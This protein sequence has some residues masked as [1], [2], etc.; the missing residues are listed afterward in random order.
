MSPRIPPLARLFLWPSLVCGLAR[1]GTSDH[2]WPTFRGPERT[3]VS[4]ESGLLQQW[5]EGGPE[6]VWETQGAGRGYASLAICDGRIYTLGD[7]PSTVDDADEYLLCFDQATGRPL[8]QSKTGPAWDSGS[9]SWRGSRS[10]PTVDGDRLYVLTA[11]GKLICFDTTGAELWRKDLKE[12]FAG[13]KADG[14]GY[15]ESVLIDGDRLV[16]T[17]GGEEHTMVALDKRSGERLWSASRP[18]DRGAGHA[19][20]VIA[21]VGPTR[22]Y[23]QTT[24]SGA[25]GVRASDGE[26]LWSYPIDRTTAVVPTPIIRE[27]LVFFSVGYRRG[28]ALL[29]QIPGEDGS[30]AMEEVYPLQTDLANKHGGIV[31][32]GDYLYGDTDDRGMPFCAEL[33]TGER[34]WRERGSGRNS[35][36]MAAADGCLYVRY[37]DGTMTLV[38]PSPE[39]LQE[40][41]SFQIPGSGDRPSWSH[42]VILDGKLYLREDDKILCY[43][44]R[45]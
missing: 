35:A 28:G 29:R 12:D 36:C 4:P 7:G 9:P 25:L 33:M 14:W 39:S 18:D 16:C 6:L 37:A 8:W 32:V 3:A 34:K 38:Q 21:Q 13:E 26:L 41:G 30:V 24:G 2:E 19:S 45:A 22:V 15:S 42:P 40:V 1:A 10:T 27:D 44:V 31:L 5:P 17:P 20:I 43:D 23:V 11:Y